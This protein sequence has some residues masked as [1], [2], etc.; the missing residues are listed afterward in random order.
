MT[1]RVLP[2]LFCAVLIRAQSPVPRAEFEVASIKPNTSAT[3]AMKFPCPVGGRFTVTNV[4][5]KTL[6][7]FAG[8]NS[9]KPMRRV[10]NADSSRP[11]NLTTLKQQLGLRLESEKAPTEILVIDHVEKPDAKLGGDAATSRV[12]SSGKGRGS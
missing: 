4:N 10:G 1:H 12:C 9:L 7:S 5:L 2:T 11:S 6:T 3:M 8:Q